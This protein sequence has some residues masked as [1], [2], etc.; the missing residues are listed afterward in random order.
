LS[1]L[2]LNAGYPWPSAAGAAK[3]T[4]IPNRMNALRIMYE[5]AVPPV[6]AAW[7]SPF[8]R[9]SCSGKADPFYKI[10]LNL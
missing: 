8:A 3:L 7:E 5:M 4:M 9:N 6:L 1:E 10:V 2:K